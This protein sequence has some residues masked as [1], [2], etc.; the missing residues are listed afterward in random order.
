MVFT[1]D[2]HLDRGYCCGN[3]CLHCPYNFEAVQQPLRSK[4]LEERNVK[5]NSTNEDE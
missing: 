2:Y 3:S 5:S 1:R 4:L